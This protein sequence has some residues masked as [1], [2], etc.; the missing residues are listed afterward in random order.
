MLFIDYGA[1]E[2]VS[3]WKIYALAE[4]FCELPCQALNVRILDNPAVSHFNSLYESV[5]SVVC[6]N[7]KGS[8][9]SNFFV[10]TVSSDN[11][12]CEK[13][14]VAVESRMKLKPHPVKFPFH[15]V[16]AHIESL[17]NFY[18]HK[19]DAVTAEKMKHLEVY[20]QS[21]YSK[22]DNHCM[23]QGKAGS[24][25]CVYS[26]SSEMYCRAIVKEADVNECLVQLLDYG[27]Y[28]KIPLKGILKLPVEFLYFPVFSIHC[29]LKDVRKENTSA[30][31]TELFKN[32]V[33]NIDILTVVQG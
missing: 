25:V 7:I 30:E 28:E 18:L 22:K 24:I 29:Q 12:E 13:R 1:I 2:M 19:L 8:D 10:A 11:L 4:E 33:A 14:M 9:G 5:G 26:S 15:A 23:N 20:L 17:S 21:F 31:N 32:I 16:V 6:L 3:R 27:H